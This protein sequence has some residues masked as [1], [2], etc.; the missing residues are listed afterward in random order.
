MIKMILDLGSKIIQLIGLTILY[1]AIRVQYVFDNYA[2]SNQT[3]MITAF[4]LIFIGL[5]MHFIA[6]ASDV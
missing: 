6:D 5:I 1:I 2:F 3:A 4:I